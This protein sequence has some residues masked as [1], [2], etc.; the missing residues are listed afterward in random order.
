MKSIFLVS[1]LSLFLLACGGEPGETSAA[2]NAPDGGPVNPQTKSSKDLVSTSWCAINL[3]KKIKKIIKFNEV[4]DLVVEVYKLVSRNKTEEKP[5]IFLVGSYSY[6][7][8]SIY[9]KTEKGSS[10]AISVNQVTSTRLVVQGPDRIGAEDGK[11]LISDQSSAENI[12][13]RACNK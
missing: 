5:F 13:Y 9:T 11:D 8:I 10:D 2:I 6:D 7:G 3:N 4:G 12:V 1:F